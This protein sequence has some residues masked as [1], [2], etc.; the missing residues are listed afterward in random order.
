MKNDPGSQ[1][2][3]E[4]EAHRNGEE[5]AVKDVFRRRRA[6]VRGAFKSF[7]VHVVGAS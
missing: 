6:G 3:A 1:S 2:P 4:E 7:G 5:E